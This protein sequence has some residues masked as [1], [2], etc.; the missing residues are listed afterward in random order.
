MRSKLRSKHWSIELRR[1]LWCAVK[2]FLLLGMLLVGAELHG[3]VWE[4]AKS[5]PSAPAAQVESPASEILLL[6]PQVVLSHLGDQQ[7]VMVVIKFADGSMEDVTAKATLGLDNASVAFL[8]GE[9]MTASGSGTA[10]LRADC[11]GLTATATIQVS[12]KAAPRTLRFRNDVLPV[13]TRAGCNA[14]KCH[15]SA[16]GKDG[17]QLSLYGFDPEG[18]F[19]RLTRE[20]SGRRIDLS[21]PDRCLLVQKATGEVPHTGGACVSPG[22]AEYRTLVTWIARGAKP[23][24]QKVPLPSSIDVYPKQIVMSQPDRAQKLIVVARYDDGSSRDVSDLAVY[25]SNNDAVATASVHGQVQATGPGSGFVMARFDQFTAGTSIIVRSGKSYP[26]LDFEANNHIDQLTAARW[27]DLHVQPSKLCSDETFL[28]RVCLDITGLLPTLEQQQRFLSDRSPDKRA[29]LI[30]Q[31]LESDNFL[32]MW[33]MQLAELLQIRNTNGLSSKGLQLYDAWLR[34]QVH[35]GV[36]VDQI[37]RQLIPASGSTFVNPATTYYQTETT[38]QLLAEN[39]AQAFLGTRIQCAQCHNHPFDRWTMDDYYGFASFVSQVGYKQARDPREIIVYNLGEGNLQHPVPGR[40]VRPKFLGGEFADLEA[41]GDLRGSLANWLTS[42]DNSSFANNIANVVW[43]HY[44]GLGIVNPVDDVRVSNPP[45]NS[46]LLNAM[47]RKLVDYKF[48]VRQLVRDICQSKTYQ[49]STQTTSW[50]EWDD[51]NFSH[52]RIRRLRAEVLLDCINQVTGTS[53][54]LAGLPLGG[55]AIEVPNGD[56]NNYF[57]STFGRA[58]RN[59]PCSC[60]VSTS[61]TLSQALHLLNGENTTAKILQG[62]WIDRQL[63]NGQT[64]IQIATN[65]YGMCL[66]RMPTTKEMEA[67]SSRLSSASDP[68]GELVDLFWAVL[69]SNEFI[70][71]H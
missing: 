69:N 53:D 26:Q 17:F 12:D 4:D 22:S 68:I 32:D 19:Y 8:V 58:S 7:R 6:P 43:A 11:S 67:I 51:R 40:N 42:T 33:A 47:G 41:G 55:R 23:D 49:L 36:P 2:A 10:Q 65:I 54:D 35:S 16:A 9:T 24:P 37:L 64:P 60:E 71:N 5:L 66:S 48:D 28:R 14:G 46:A 50:N 56:S 30:D 27:Q 39:I 63:D 62:Q 21:Q 3:R 44:L 31:L 57:L 38:P 61:P 13:L 20:M 45:S 34:Q 70:F 1:S 52:A 18:D 15:G 25:I 59:T 29:T